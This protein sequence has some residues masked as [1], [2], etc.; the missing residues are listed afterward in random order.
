LNLLDQD[1]IRDVYRVL[2]Y[3]GIPK[4]CKR[5]YSGI[6]RYQK[7]VF[8]VEA[9]IRDNNQWMLTDPSTIDSRNRARIL[10]VW[11]SLAHSPPKAW[12]AKGGQGSGT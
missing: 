4:G 11:E 8:D 5:R 10:G 12:R 9:L 7:Q 1:S 6:D 3:N 2:G